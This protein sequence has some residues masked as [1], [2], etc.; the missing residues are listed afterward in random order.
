MKYLYALGAVVALV[1]LAST[2][3]AQPTSL[4]V[5]PA[6]LP[7]VGSVSPRY[8]SYNVEMI[9]VTGGKFWKPYAQAEQDAP[10]SQAATP[11]G[12]TPSAYSYRP[13]A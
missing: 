4:K 10:K 1:G 7:K 11:V 13:P 9:E 8:Q 6:A 5:D 2:S 3:T 12:T